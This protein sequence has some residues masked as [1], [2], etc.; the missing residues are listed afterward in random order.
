MPIFLSSSQALSRQRIFC[1]VCGSGLKAGEQDAGGCWVME[2]ARVWIIIERISLMRT[3]PTTFCAQHCRK[4]PHTYSF[5]KK[6]DKS[7][8][9]NCSML[10]KNSGKLSVYRSIAILFLYPSL[11][12][13]FVAPLETFL[14]LCFLAAMQ[15]YVSSLNHLHFAVPVIGGK[16]HTLSC[17]LSPLAVSDLCDWSIRAASSWSVAC[18]LVLIINKKCIRVHDCSF[19]FFPKWLVNFQTSSEAAFLLKFESPCPFQIF[20]ML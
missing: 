12:V 10:G 1:S 16:I 6:L 11:A 9:I 14:C 2:T 5:K 8:A 15:Q 17:Q 20:C 18:A 13:Y 4:Q 7:Q 19:F 3:L